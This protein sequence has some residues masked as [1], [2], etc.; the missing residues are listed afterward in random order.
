MGSGGLK[1]TGFNN[2][3]GGH[4]F[5]YNEIREHKKNLAQ[6]LKKQTNKFL[7]EQN[8]SYVVPDVNFLGHV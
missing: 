7:S 8:N 3:M 5:S 6:S 1:Q 2:P 4:L